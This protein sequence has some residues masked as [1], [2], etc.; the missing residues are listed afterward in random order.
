MS[1][2]LLRLADVLAELP[3]AQR[4]AIVLHHFE[5][6]T[7]DEIGRQLDRSATAVAGLIKRGL[8][9]LRLRLSDAD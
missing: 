3:E 8:R 5:Q 1:V 2:V 6:R 4:E 9:T 7:V